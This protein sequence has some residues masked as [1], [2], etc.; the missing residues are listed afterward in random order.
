MGVRVSFH[1]PEALGNAPVV[2]LTGA[3]ASAALGY[4]TTKTFLSRVFG[5]SNQ[6]FASDREVMNYL[7]MLEAEAAQQNWDVEHVLGR[8]ERL[9]SAFRTLK[10]EL[11]PRPMNQ[12]MIA[13]FRDADQYDR[14]RDFIYDEVLGAYGQGD[15]DRAAKLFRPFL[16]EF[17]SW[18]QGVPGMGRTLPWFTLN[19]DRSVE[20]AAS[21]LDDGDGRAQV[22]LVD[23]LTTVRRQ[24]ERRWERRQFLDYEE[25]PLAANVVLVKLHGSVR[26]GASDEDGAIVELPQ[27]LP[28]NPGQYRHAILYP[29]LEPKPLR[30]EPFRTGYRVLRTCLY[31]TSVLIVVGCSLRD[32]ELRH[33]ISDAMD[34]N[35]SLHLIT[36]S[37]HADAAR[38]ANDLTLPLDRVAAVQAKFEP[39]EQ[40]NEYFM[41]CLRDLA[42][43]ATATAKQAGM[44]AFGYTYAC[45]PTGLAP[46]SKA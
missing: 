34:E 18:F 44:P 41:G 20:L 29:S 38:T 30:D 43:S 35:D 37:P 39:Q 8:L 32:P 11:P 4:P 12:A 28:R 7:G 5:A 21:A 17:W 42:V 2:L 10:E 16:Q 25:D 23:G 9:S 1:L 3:G 22:R 15:P 45:T 13:S 46:V 26:W 40:P 19:Y 33:E 36:V 24:T 6:R 27:G 14:V 31:K